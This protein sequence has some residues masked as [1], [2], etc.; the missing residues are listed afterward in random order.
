MFLGDLVILSA[1]RVGEDFQNTHTTASNIEQ[2]FRERAMDID[3]IFSVAEFLKSV[4]SR[5]LSLFSV[6]KNNPL[7]TIAVVSFS[8]GICVGL[9]AGG[10]LQASGR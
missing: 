8:T 4:E 10:R 6:M 9:V 5:A 1:G 2:G 7:E 3:R